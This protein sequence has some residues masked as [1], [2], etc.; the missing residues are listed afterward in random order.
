MKARKKRKLENAGFKVGTVQEFLGLSDEEIGATQFR[1]EVDLA[2][3]DPASFT[4]LRFSWRVRLG[5]KAQDVR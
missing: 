2:F 3:G 4:G 5:V 1:H